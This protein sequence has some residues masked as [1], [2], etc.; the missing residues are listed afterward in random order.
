MKTNKYAALVG[1][2]KN[3]AKVVLGKRKPQEPE[4]PD[5][6]ANMER[7]QLVGC[8]RILWVHSREKC[9]GE[10]CCIHNPSDHHMR[11]WPQNWRGDRGL[12]ERICPHGIGHPDPDDPA[13]KTQYGGIHGCDG[14]C[15][16]KAE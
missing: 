4:I 8:D 14:C 1:E 12:M 6:Y 10:F 9:A 3:L 11:E 15:N 2:I 7:Y 16:P 13:T 5:P